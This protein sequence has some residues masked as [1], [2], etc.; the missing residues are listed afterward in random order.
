ML[1][2][3]F[4]VWWTDVDNALFTQRSDDSK[5]TFVDALGEGS[6]GFTKDLYRVSRG[7]DLFIT[8]RWAIDQPVSSAVYLYSRSRIKQNLDADIYDTPRERYGS[9]PGLIM[10]PELSPTG[11]YVA[12]QWAQTNLDRIDGKFKLWIM[13]LWTGTADVAASALVWPLP[14]AGDAILG[15]DW[16]SDEE[17]VVH[18]KGRNARLVRARDGASK[19]LPAPPAEFNGYT[20]VGVSYSPDGQNVVGLMTRDGKTHEV[21]VADSAYTTLRQV[22]N[23][24]MVINGVRWASSNLLHLSNYQIEGIGGIVTGGTIVNACESYVLP[25]GAENW[26]EAQVRAARP[27]NLPCNFSVS[28]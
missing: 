28:K 4:H 12:A 1:G 22:T 10:D 8:Y 25:V 5:S 3:P 14:R 6:I 24:G 26:T 13:D 2:E 18:T 19:P 20:I 21:F 27:T 7:G 16:V 23:A 15:I 11:R 9:S 17:F